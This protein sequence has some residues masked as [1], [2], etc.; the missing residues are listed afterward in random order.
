M[1]KEAA[2]YVDR[3]CQRQRYIGRNL[4]TLGFELYKARNAVS[5]KE[6]VTKH[7]YRLALM[8]FDTMGKEIFSFCSFI[9]SYSM[10]TIL[11]ALMSD[12][13]IGVEEQLFNSGV[14]DVV[15]GKQTSARVLIK[16]IQAHLHTN[17]PPELQTNTIRLKDVLV[18]FDRKEVFCN[19]TVRRLPGILADLLRYFLD[20]STRVISREELRESPVWAESICSAPEEGGK[21]FDVNISKLRKIVEP[22]PSKPQIIISVRGVGWKL[23]LDSLR[24]I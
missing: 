18:D 3:N 1:Y 16:R 21:T 24:W 22:E 11:I 5:A 7:R 2:L 4:A 10:H 12:I 13:K 20:N 6:M 9:H 17:R 23:A 19:G 14:N 8:H 15:S